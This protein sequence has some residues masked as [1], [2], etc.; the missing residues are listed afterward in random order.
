MLVELNIANYAVIDQLRLTL[1]AGFN[2]MTGQTGA[3]KSI[4]L[5]ALGLLLGDR[6]DAGMVRAG[7]ERA[8]I[9]GIFELADEAAARVG[10]LLDHDVHEEGLILSREVSAGGRNVCRVNGRA[11]PQRRFAEVGALIVD[12]HGQSEH[13]SLLRPGEHLELLDR[14]AGLTGLRGRLA[15][16]V[17]EL[18]AVRE[19]LARIGREQSELQARLDLLTFQSAEIAAAALEPGEDE[20]L[21]AERTLLLNAEK[22]CG[23]AREAVGALEQD[24]PAH[25]GAIE[26]IGMAVRSLA[27]L[28]KFQPA[29][30]P[31]RLIAESAMVELQELVRELSLFADGLHADDRRL[32]QI[33]ARLDL[34]GGLKRKYGSDIDEVL[35]FGRRAAEELHQAGTGARTQQ[36]LLGQ[37]PELE[38][39][40]AGLAAELSNERARG[41]GTLT[42]AVEEQLEGLG[43]AGARLAVVIEQ[44]A[45][46]A[47][48]PLAAH[49]LSAFDGVVQSGQTLATGEGPPERLRFDV[50]GVDRVEFLIAPNLGEPLKPLASTASGGETSRL[51]L[52]I[53]GALAKADPLPILVFD[54]IDAGIGGKVGEA[55]GRRLWDLGRH[56]QVLAVTHLPQIASCGDR[57]FAVRKLVEGG[58]TTTRAV[59]VTGAERVAEI[60]GML[61]SDSVATRKKAQELLTQSAGIITG[62]A[63]QL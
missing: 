26:M 5:G 41:A 29:L 44:T 30:E 50:T 53:K 58:R 57:H 1:G 61:G 54:E 10:A 62:G 45:H 13:L 34:L 43:M 35:A 8:Y 63:N 60:G 31:Q 47:G 18:T 16:V 46:Q 52:A 3:G 12:I 55:V 32:E 24:H 17:R 51:M 59:E 37:L 33:Q 23:L 15:E 6:A 38:A 7:E 36:D 11:V 28:E 27:A 40:A 25:P 4:I 14:Y 20:A 19:R 49:G 21:S 9:E 48:L 2:V 56:H 39:Q 22:A 42:T